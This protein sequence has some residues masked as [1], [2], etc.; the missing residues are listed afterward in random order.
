LGKVTVVQTTSNPESL[1]R[2]AALRASSHYPVRIRGVRQGQRIDK[3]I[4]CD[5]ISEALNAHDAWQTV[6]ERAARDAA[7]I[8]SNTGD[9]GYR[10]HDGD[11]AVLLDGV[12]VPVSFPAKLAVLLH[13]RYRAGAAPITLLP[14]E[15]ISNNGDTLRE[16][17]RGV[18]RGW[19]TGGAFD[20][21]LTQGCV[22]GNSLVDRIVA[23]PIHPVGAVAEPYA[24]WAIQRQAK[25]TLPCSHP[26]I[27]V[28][29]DLAHHERLKLLLLNLGHSVL[30]ELWRTSPQSASGAPAREDLTVREAMS[31]TAMRTTLEAVWRDEV[32]P[33]FGA[34]G[35]YDEAAAYLMDVRDRFENPYLD[36]RLSDI[37]QNHVEK[38]RRRFK[39]AV[40]MARWHA[41]GIKQRFLLQA[42]QEGN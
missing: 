36:H 11:D 33:V 31:D 9:A 28:T 17:V 15:L 40:E 3:T 25:M 22:W 4:E 21:Y 5:A 10:L 24:L 42:L 20:E 1:A 2:I 27:L 6:R 29:D 14:C 7:L 16:L 38:K 35:K 18:A 8:V 34:L 23:S 37:A 12:Q 41:L 30:A 26:D 39:P 13:G 19:R 32:L